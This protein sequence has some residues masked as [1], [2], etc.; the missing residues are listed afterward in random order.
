MIVRA[1]WLAAAVLGPTSADSLPPMPPA[2]MIVT[3]RGQRSVPVTSRRGHPAIAASPLV[4]LL[5]MTQLVQDGWATVRFAGQSF[6]F[7]L[8]APVLVDEGRLVPLVGGA[9]VERDS[10]FVP[11]QWLTDYVPRRFREAYR[12]D[13]LAARFEETGFTPVVR[14][15]SPP[16]NAA[17]LRDSHMVVIDPGHGGA[18][19]GNPGRFLPRGMQEK[20]VTLAISR[21]IRDEL[22]RQGVTVVL[23]RTTDTLIGLYDRADFCLQDCDLFVSVHVNALDPSPGY[24]RVSGVNTYFLGDA[25]TAESRRVAAIE[26]EA[27][28]YETGRPFEPDDPR[29]FIMK[30]LQT[31]EFLRESALLADLVQES[32]SAVHPGRNRGVAQNRFVVLATA[33]RPA[34]LVETGFATNRTDAQYLASRRGQQRLAR[35]IADSIVEYLRR[36]EAKTGVGAP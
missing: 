32:A 30:A 11:L 8:G 31:N 33:Q 4:S 14:S 17:G 21:Y 1:L 28:R 18:D 36:Y 2:V 25:L 27:V 26:N 10:L 24:Q 12:Y 15:P 7:L 29:L 35:A 3:S 13:P 9:F 6:R 16:A 34:I 20:H 22:E 23:T 5:P 19:R